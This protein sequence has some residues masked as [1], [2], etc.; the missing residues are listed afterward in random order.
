MLALG[1][2]P[3]LGRS[4]GEGKGY[5]LQYS[6]LENSMDCIT[7]QGVAK[8]RTQLSDFHFLISRAAL[9]L[10][11]RPPLPSARWF[12]SDVILRRLQSRP[13]LPQG[14]CL[15][16]R[17]PGVGGRPGPPYLLP[18]D[19]RGGRAGGLGAVPGPVGLRGLW[20]TGSLRRALTLR[21]PMAPLHGGPPPRAGRGLAGGT[22]SRPPWSRQP[23]QEHGLCRWALSPPVGTKSDTQLPEE[24]DSHTPRRERMYWATDCE[25]PL[26]QKQTHAA[27]DLFK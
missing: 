11:G 5:P 7:V 13:P 14:A 3:G 19:L 22:F 16:V 17:T 8:S 10:P 20:V 25:D 23:G 2:I 15:S 21:A 4:P 18:P 27:T 26:F 24:K 6:G 9:S 12:S 1:L